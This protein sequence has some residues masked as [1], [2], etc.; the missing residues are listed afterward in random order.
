MKA[1]RLMSA[2]LG[3][4]MLLSVSVYAHDGRGGYG[5][6]GYYAPSHYNHGSWIV[7]LAVGGILGY[8]LSEP[9]RESVTYVQPVPSRVIYP[10]QPV[11]QEQWV[12]FNDCDC[13]RK[14]LVQIR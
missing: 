14:V 2:A 3:T 4:V 12:Y 6:G 8:A 7:P 9:R 11:Y 10:A 13:Q 1:L 5:R